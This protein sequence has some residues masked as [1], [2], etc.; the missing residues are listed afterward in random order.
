MIVSVD[1]RD[2]ATDVLP[3]EINR[4]AIA[5]PGRGPLLG[6][7]AAAPIV[8]SGLT[9]DLLTLGMV[10]VKTCIRLDVMALHEKSIFQ[11]AERIPNHAIDPH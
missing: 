5:D 6:S 3:L 8:T 4:L 10:D 9:K 1:L 11:P 7:L 2:L